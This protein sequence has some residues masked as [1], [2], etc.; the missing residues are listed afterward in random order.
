MCRQEPHAAQR[1]RNGGDRPAIAGPD[2]VLTGLSASYSV[3]ATLSD[4]ITGTV[5]PAWTSSNAEVASVDSGGRVEGR[6][7]GSTNL[8][9][10][11]Q[12]RSV[13]KTVQVVNNYGGTWEGSY[14]I[15]A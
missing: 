5:R 7:H 12:G 1:V 10:S 11:Y 9:A 15:R 13:S 14:V 6:G 3:T 2:A 4:G 8:T